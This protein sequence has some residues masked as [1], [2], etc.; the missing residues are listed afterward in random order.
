[1]KSTSLSSFPP[2]RPETPP[3]KRLALTGTPD[4]LLSRN[5]AFRLRGILGV[6]LLIPALFFTLFSRPVVREGTWTSI[7]FNACA[8]SVFLAGI[9]FRV[10]ATLYVGGRKLKTLVDQGPYSICRNP[11]YL[12]TF[13]MSLGFVLFLK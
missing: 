9:L 13:L 3:S 12:G 11:L 4:K 2:A 1:M 10:W 8:W 6:S 7:L 5:P